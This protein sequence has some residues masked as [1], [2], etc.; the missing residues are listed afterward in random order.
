MRHEVVTRWYTT[1]R[2]ARPTRGRAGGRGHAA[3]CGGLTGTKGS[4]VYS[5]GSQGR[6]Q[7]L[8]LPPAVGVNTALFPA[9]EGAGL[10][11][12]SLK[13]PA[14]GRTATAAQLNQAGEELDRAHLRRER[15]GG[16]VLREVQPVHA[17]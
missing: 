15:G 7:T 17:A 11:A 8:P 1:L 14:G 13:S 2:S 4:Q 9:V 12:A 6:G 10:V 16:L 3:R 5:S